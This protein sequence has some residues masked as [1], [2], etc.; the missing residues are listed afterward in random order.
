[1]IAHDELYGGNDAA[2]IEAIL[3]EEP[4]ASAAAQT[5][6][7]FTTTT[8]LLAH[9]GDLAVEYG[10]GKPLVIFQALLN[11]YRAL[12]RTQAALS[13]AAQEILTTAE[14]LAAEG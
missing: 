2:T 10:V 6:E 7:A 9:I 12:S 13:A 4:L 11:T 1:M 3:T 14:Q 5:I 8:D